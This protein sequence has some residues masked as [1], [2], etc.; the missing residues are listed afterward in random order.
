MSHPNDSTLAREKQPDTGLIPLRT[1]V[2]DEYG[3]WYFWRNTHLRDRIHP[4]G[5]YWHETGN[6]WDEEPYPDGAM[7]FARLI[8][9]RLLEVAPPL[10]EAGTIPPPCS[11]PG[12]ATCDGIVDGEDLALVL[13][14]WGHIDAT[15]RQGDIDGD[16]RV[17]GADL[18]MLFSYW[19]ACL[20][21]NDG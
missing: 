14:Y 4:R 2:E 12:D 3:Q 18:T 9:D 17:D 11:C 19:G 15:K 5:P 13:I 20:D 8:W 16:G 1:M 7:Y 21:G 10:D 6:W